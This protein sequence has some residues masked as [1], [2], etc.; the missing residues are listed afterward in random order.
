[1]YLVT[2]SSVKQLAPHTLIQNET[3]SFKKSKIKFWKTQICSCL[4]CSSISRPPFP[5]IFS[6]KDPIFISVYRLWKYAISRKFEFF[7][8]FMP[9]WHENDTKIKLSQHV[10]KRLY[11]N[12]LSPYIGSLWCRNLRDFERCTLCSSIFHFVISDF[13][14]K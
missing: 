13:L 5:T 10:A 9:F 7:I 2:L 6:E 14:S 11:L 12:S 4:F 8:D 3:V 1:L